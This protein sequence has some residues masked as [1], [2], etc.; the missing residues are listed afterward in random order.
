MDY[1][2]AK[3]IIATGILALGTGTYG[4]LGS[5]SGYACSGGQDNFC[6]VAC[7]Y[8]GLPWTGFCS[9][10]FSW[11]VCGCNG[12]PITCYPDDECFPG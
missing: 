10:N 5:T 8:Y 6:I 4:L 1:R 2:N 7:E 9:W 3:S 11:Q 12:E